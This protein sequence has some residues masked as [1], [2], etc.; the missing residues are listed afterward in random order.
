MCVDDG[1][2]GDVCDGVFVWYIGSDVGVG[3]IV[4]GGEVEDS[5]GDGGLCFFL[6]CGEC[7]GGEYAFFSVHG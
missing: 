1:S 3:S 5:D 2:E 6:V 4:F 7:F